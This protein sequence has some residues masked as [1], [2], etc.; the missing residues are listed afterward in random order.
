MLKNY[1]KIAYRNLLKNKI[2]SLVNIAGLA[3]GMAACFF[4]FLY[5]HFERSYDGWHKNIVNLYRVP[6]K[7]SGSLMNNTTAATNHPAV[8]PAMKK[9]FPE[10]VDY[11][12]L[13]LA[14]TFIGTTMMSYTNGNQTVT[15][16]EDRI[17]FTDPSLLT[18]FSFP[19]T[20][21][22][23]HT[24]LSGKQSIVISDRIAKKY[25]GNQDPLGK[26]VSIN[27]QTSFKVTGVFRDIPENSHLK[28]DVLLP[29]QVL[30]STELDA[31]WNWPEFYTYVQL[32]PG[33]D[34]RKVEAKFPAFIQKYMGA[35]MKQLKYGADFQLQPVRDIHLRSNL[36]KETEANGS[37]KEIA[38][39]TMIGI[40]ILVIAWI[41]YI[42]L[43]TA[44]ST[45]RAKE[46]GIRKVAGAAKVQLI[47]QFMMESAIVN[48]LALLV[49]A[50]L[51]AILYPHFG[52][53]IG[54]DIRD[55]SGGS[56]WFQQ[57]GFWLGLM[58]LLVGGALLVGAYPAF[59]LS[60]FRPILVLKGRFFQSSRGI[61]LRKALVSFQFVLSILLIA[62]AITVY[63]QLSY[64]QNQALG[65]NKDQVLVLKA[66][67]IYD[68]TWV[69]KMQSL[70]DQLL[71]NPSVLSISTSSDIPGQTIAGR[72]SVRKLSEDE[73]HNFTPFYVNID[74]DFLRTFQIQLAAGRGLLSADMTNLGDSET[75]RVLVNE[76]VV[77]GMGFKNDEA[78]I[79]QPILFRYGKSDRKG[80]I[81]GVIKNYHQRSL[82]E[83]YDPILLFE[84]KFNNWNYIS[85]RLKTTDVNHS[86]AS[87]EKTYKDL[88]VGNAFEYF[89]LDDYFNR[90]YQSDQRF[91]NIFSLF[92]GL[93]IFVA[94][95]GL[96]GLSSFVIKMRTKEIGV[97]KVLGASVASL[98]LLFSGDFIKLVALAS[99]I[100]LPIIY[101]SA[102]RWLSNY[103]FHVGLNWWIFALPPLLLLFISLTTICLQSLKTALSSPTKNLR[104]E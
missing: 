98:L 12:R 62:G 86:L 18:M 27:Q 2:F 3:I 50:G 52:A 57:P 96:L 1:L 41:N 102:S 60:S 37:E 95:L 43:S 22:D 100:A 73:T 15:F 87:F 16:N 24:A 10:V 77:K 23:P 49:A 32:A 66:P 58:G 34:P 5:V 4:I 63:S 59:V 29:L 78:A 74:Q 6:V 46:V 82:R 85:V 31:T 67:A 75:T 48:L 26:T 30:G 9:D 81:V 69:T 76:E 38:F 68:S 54:K 47:I 104:T 80:E 33:T 71:A 72:N 103:A 35:L 21:G 56:S 36:E 20:E 13:A 42:N 51:V 90:Q 17:Y 84:P 101:I 65:Y 91:G 94:C 28:F 14:P 44:R 11:A 79:N 7:F 19:F 45:E 93:A 40:F 97:R 89:F 53:F 55:N 25:F 64:M 88:F 61:L 39:L 99:L 83:G 92:T 8:G 70:K